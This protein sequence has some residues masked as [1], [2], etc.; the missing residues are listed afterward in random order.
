VRAVQLLLVGL[1]ILP[2]ALLVLVVALVVARREPDPT[3][4]G[5]Y[6]VY[7]FLVTFL[8]LFIA[9]FAFAGVVTQIVKLIQDAPQPQPFAGL[10]GITGGD[11]GGPLTGVVPTFDATAEYWRSLLQA[12]TV[13][14]AAVGVLWFHARR[15]LELLGESATRTDATARVYRYYLYATLLVAVL[16]LL[17]SSASGVYGLIRVIGPGLTA[18]TS[19]AAERREGVE[20]LVGGAF[21]A[22]TMGA[23]FVFHWR[24]REEDDRPAVRAGAAVVPPATT[25]PTPPAT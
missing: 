22:L 9:S 16:T 2:I 17:F 24:K 20:Q 12:L 23:I 8:A 10:D 25:P 7:V 14:L 19:D 3:G 13:G 5:V 21:L 11:L 1:L 6:G 15:A 4:R 18:T